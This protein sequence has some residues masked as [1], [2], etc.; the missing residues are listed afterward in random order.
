MSNKIFLISL[1]SGVIGP[2]AFVSQKTLFLRLDK[3]FRCEP[4][5]K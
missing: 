2:E 4:S 5:S 1:V 3:F